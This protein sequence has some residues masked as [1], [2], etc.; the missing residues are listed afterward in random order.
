MHIK[1][2]SEEYRT[3]ILAMFKKIGQRKQ[4]IRVLVLYMNGA[5]DSVFT[6]QYATSLAQN[7]GVSDKIRFYPGSYK[8]PDFFRDSMAD[9]KFFAKLDYVIVRPDLSSTD[10]VAERLLK[11][12]GAKPKIFVSSSYRDGPALSEKRS[13]GILL[14]ILKMAVSK[15]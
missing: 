14:E 15:H 6:V 10:I 4:P 3:K 2:V 7:I 1:T 12:Y 13:M 8:Q 5:I 11:L 9:K